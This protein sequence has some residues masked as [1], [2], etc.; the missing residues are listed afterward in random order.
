M[1][2]R[3]NQQ[4]ILLLATSRFSMR[5]LCEK[6]NYE[7]SP[8]RLSSTDKLAEA[9]WSG[10]LH[11]TMPEM[12]QKATSGKSLYIWHIH[13]RSTSLH[14]ML[15]DVPPTIEAAFSIEPQH[16]LGGIFNN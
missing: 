4:E 13:H 1:K 6:L 7:A 11:E 10:L 12:I 5:E 16:F 15:S 14:I 8:R 9:C 3:N 2:Q